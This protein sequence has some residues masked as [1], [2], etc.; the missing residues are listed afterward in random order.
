MSSQCQLKRWYLSMHEDSNT[1]VD[2]SVKFDSSYCGE[3]TP[4]SK[5]DP[6][7]LEIYTVLG[8]TDIGVYS[9]DVAMDHIQKLK[10]PDRKLDYVVCAAIRF[11]DIVVASP[12]HWDRICANTFD[13]FSNE[14]KTKIALIRKQGGEEQGFL[15]STGK[16][17]SRE[18]ALVLAVKN[19]QFGLYG[20]DD[21]DATELFSENLYSSHGA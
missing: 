4:K 3:S 21:V 12:R 13:N 6:K 2:T 8:L 9:W 1:G 11:G 20:V 5:V 10:K 18:D 17:V 14:I 15:L 7:L 16:Y 19:R